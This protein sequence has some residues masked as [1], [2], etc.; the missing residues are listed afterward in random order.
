VVA[1]REYAVPLQPT[2]AVIPFLSR[3]NVPEQFAI[4]DLIADGIIATLSQ[5]PRLRVMS[6]LSTSSLRDTTSDLRTINFL[7]NADFA[8]SG[9]YTCFNSKVLIAWELA[10]TKTKQVLLSERLTTSLDD[11]LAASSDFFTA[12]S[13]S[14]QNAIVEVEVKKANR[15]PMPTLESYSLMLSGVSLM[16]RSGAHIQER[17]YE[18]LR[19]LT[20]RHPGLALPKSWLAKWYILRSVSGAMTDPLLEGKLA[21]SL[22]QRA[23][24]IDPGD[25]M[26]LA[27]QGYVYNHLLGKP[28]LAAQRLEQAV[29]VN[30]NDSLAWL[31][32]SVVLAMWG[33]SLG[34]VASAERALAL[35]PIDPLMYFYHS[36]H[37]SALLAN[38]QA[39]QAISI[40]EKSLRLNRLHLPTYRVLLTAQV[41]VGQS[42]KALET[43]QQLVKLD[44]GFSLLSYEKGG[45]IESR[46]KQ[47]TIQALKAIEY[48]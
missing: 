22:T 42:E 45:N 25:S 13:L 12:I 21:L 14:I 37:A 32:R 5:C 3:S 18:V 9:S 34:G 1:Q 16:H 8:L 36:L 31:Y 47:Q 29:L 33:D 15:Q 30:P 28:D 48:L 4:G 40:S 23:I 11:L 39:H 2:I 6:R 20:E 19:H 46:T 41:M 17:S 24:D 38:G 35:S 27:M 44:P 43:K 7:L 26:S 10:E